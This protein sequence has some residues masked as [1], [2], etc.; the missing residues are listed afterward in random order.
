[1]QNF[2]NKLVAVA[3]LGILAAI[4][5]MMTPHYAAAQA[6]PPTGTSG[7]APVT[8]VSPIPLPVTQSGAWNVGIV[9]GFPSSLTIGNLA[10]NPVLTRDVDS[11]SMQPFQAE[12]HFTITNG[13]GGAQLPAIPAGKRFVVEH[14]SINFFLVPTSGIDFCGL[15]VQPNFSAT[16]PM[17][18][19]NTGGDRYTGNVQTKVYL[20]ATLTPG[21]PTVQVN[22][23]NFSSGGSA[24]AL[25]S[26]YLV[27]IS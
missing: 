10:M 21:T 8:I 5:S 6:A 1:M 12:L 19:Q 9:S 22:A 17:V 13:Q 26:G 7:S 3:A 20:D 15:A 11:F 16:D 4:G 27:P 14:M 25:V 2:R 18:C 24:T 23:S